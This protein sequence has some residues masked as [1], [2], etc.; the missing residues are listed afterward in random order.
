MLRELVLLILLYISNNT[1]YDTN[2][3]DIGY[4]NINFIEEKAIEE[5]SK[6]PG[7]V[8]YYTEDGER[9]F[10][11][12]YCKSDMKGLT[13]LYCESL[14][15][16]ELTHFVQD[17]NN[18]H[19]YCNGILEVEAYMLQQKYALERGM[20]LFIEKNIREELKNCNGKATFPPSTKQG[21]L[22]KNKK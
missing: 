10:L 6:I 20:Q 17:M 13:N 9:I 22:R 18:I 7:A 4:P 1:S 12:S 16:H 11:P 15:V 21:V 19:P 3:R 2:I 14:L 5:N 8:A